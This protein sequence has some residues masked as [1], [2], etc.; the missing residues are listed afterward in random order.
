MWEIHRDTQGNLEIFFLACG[1]WG[2]EVLKLC[3]MGPAGIKTQT[4]L[5]TARLLVGLVAPG[6]CCFRPKL[7]VPFRWVFVM[8]IRAFSCL[9]VLSTPNA[10]RAELV[11]TLG[12]GVCK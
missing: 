9:E 3:Q 2:M 7:S 4:S 10:L 12:A 5:H 11:P 1:V 6:S 8:G